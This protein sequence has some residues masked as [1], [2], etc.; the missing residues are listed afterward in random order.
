VLFRSKDYDHA[1][2]D[3]RLVETAAENEN[4]LAMVLAEVADD[5]EHEF[6]LVWG[7]RLPVEIDGVMRVLQYGPATHEPPV[8]KGPDSAMMAR[9]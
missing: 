1:R 9:I 6:M 4:R 3:R 8:A 5:H 2:A 7:Q